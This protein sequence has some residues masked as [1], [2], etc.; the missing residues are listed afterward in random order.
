VADFDAALYVSTDCEDISNTCV[1]GADAALDMESFQLQLQADVTYHIFVDGYGIDT[2]RNGI[3]TLHITEPCVPQCD[4][5]SCGDDGCQ[6]VCGQ[7]PDGETCDPAG[8][9]H[10]AQQGDHCS[11]PI[12]VTGLPYSHNWDTSELSADYHYEANQCPGMPLGWGLASND[13][14]YAFTPEVNDV[15]IITLNAAF[16][17]TL[18]VTTGCEVSTTC[19]A[20]DE[21]SLM[22]E[23]LSL[24]LE[25][26]VTVFIFVDGYGNLSNPSGDFTLTIDTDCVPD[27]ADKEC[28][29][30]GCGGS[31][32]ECEGTL[33]CDDEG[34]CTELPGNS[35]LAPFPIESLP[36][37]TPSTASTEDATHELAV[38]YDACPGETGVVGGGSPE[39]VYA[40]TPTESGVYT[41]EVDADFSAIV[42]VVTDCTIFAK[43]CFIPKWEGPLI[44]FQVDW[45]CKKPAASD[46]GGIE[47]TYLLTSAQLTL[48]IWLEADTPYFIV[49]DGKSNAES[50]ADKGAYQLDISGPCTPECENRE[51]G[52]DGCGLT[53]G[54][55][56]EGLVCD[57]PTGQCEA[58]PGNACTSPFIVDTIPFNASDSTN[59]ATNV[60]G[61]PYAGCFNQSPKAGAGSKDEV[62]AFTPE[63]PGMYDITIDTNFVAAT[64]VLNDCVPY[65]STCFF[66]ETY[67]LNTWLDVLPEC[68]FGD[69]CLAMATGDD[70]NTLKLETELGQTYYIVV[71]G[72]GS[73]SNYSGSYSLTIE[74][75]CDPQCEEKECGDDGCGDV[76]GACSGGFICDEDGQC[77]DTTIENGNTCE[78]AWTVTMDPTFIGV[79]DTSDKSDV[80]DGSQ[81]VG[82]GLPNG[83]DSRDEVWAFTPQETGIYVITVNPTA[84]FQAVVY[85]METCGDDDGNLDCVMGTSEEIMS[86]ALMAG[87]TYHVI[88]DGWGVGDVSGSYVLE[89]NKF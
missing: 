56:E 81:C 74:K 65:Y 5:K 22:G 82:S 44:W 68:S 60:Y 9:C 16:D 31:C 52:S 19:I 10:P 42:Y 23:T 30:D 54:T 85:V 1:Q 45:D 61:V 18:Y 70:I 73:L 79:G 37:S 62:Y 14:V 4:D 26:D 76:C 36:F 43:D 80:Y 59:N 29:T 17:S 41:V 57:E 15:Y 88:V 8:Q 27:C 78:N 13:A 83:D 63:I 55:C 58:Q 20:A 24:S 35:C 89:I 66:E 69:E 6:G 48:N 84:G 2:D 11:N 53:C 67:G 38:P 47:S 21:Q 12:S 33:Q 25:A 75:G 72:T 77:V 87:T 49:V 86:P 28:G 64:Y 50:E 7:C 39:E 51:C 34:H 3:Y 40:F 71:D 32:G 46:C